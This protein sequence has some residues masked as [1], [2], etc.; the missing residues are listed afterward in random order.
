MCLALTFGN[1]R[2]GRGAPREHGLVGVFDEAVEFAQCEF[3]SLAFSG[4]IRSH[5]LGR[6]E[7][8]RQ[9]VLES[10]GRKARLDHDGSSD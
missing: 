8:V 9:F 5:A 2:L 10:V 3:P 4:K 6:I 1:E 7:G